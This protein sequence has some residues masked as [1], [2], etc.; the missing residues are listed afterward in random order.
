[1][2]FLTECLTSFED[3]VSTES[4]HILHTAKINYDWKLPEEFL[5]QKE[6]EQE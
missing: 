4:F 3:I 6:G 2:T 5:A 1:M